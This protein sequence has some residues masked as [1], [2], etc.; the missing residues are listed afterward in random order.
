VGKGV[1][2]WARVLRVGM[3]VGVE[4]ISESMVL[5]SKVRGGEVGGGRPSERVRV[6]GHIPKKTDKQLPVSVWGE[7]CHAI[8]EP[9]PVKH[10]KTRKHRCECRG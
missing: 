10:L 2:V 8:N 6:G 9:K 5:K 1:E 7:R 3:G 4:A